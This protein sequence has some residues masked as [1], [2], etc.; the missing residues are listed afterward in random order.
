MVCIDQSNDQPLTVILDESQI[1][2]VNPG[3]LN[4]PTVVEY[5][6]GTKTRGEV[7]GSLGPGENLRIDVGHEQ[8]HAIGA[9]EVTS[10]RRTDTVTKRTGL[11]NQILVYSPESGEF[12]K[13]TIPVDQ[14]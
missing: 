4:G 6:D 1:Q 2:V 10:L 11:A 8:I 3:I 14:L 9:G 13:L 5:S 12:Y 7:T